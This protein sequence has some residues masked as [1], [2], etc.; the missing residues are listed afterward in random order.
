MQLYRDLTGEPIAHAKSC[1]LA[2]GGFDGLHVGH[3]ALIKQLTERAGTLNCQAVLLSFEPLPR[4]YF[5]QPGFFR[6][7]R[8][9]EKLIES[10]RLGLDI[11]LLTRFNQTLTELSPEQFVQLLTHKLAP[12]E[13]WVG[14]DFRFGH[15]R[16]GSVATLQEMSQRYGYRVVVVDDV[17][18]AG[19]RVSSSTI[20][21]L[22]LQGNLTAANRK[23]GRNFSYS[24][25]VVQGQQLARTLG[26]AT[27]NL[28][29]LDAPAPL[30]GVY[31][32][33]VSGEGFTQHKGVASLGVRPVVQGAACW[34]E[35][36]LFDFDAD[37][38]G[39]RLRVEFIEKLR[40]ELHF[41]GLDA[42][43]TQVNIDIAQAK[44]I[45]S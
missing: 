7:T 34:L 36:H 19:E 35:V 41:D 20:R 29:W 30:Y 10:M 18:H 43:I 26:F 24:N 5:R 1:V 8:T 27:A 42:L 25:R 37:L 44:A 23:L 31:A 40:P 3:Q 6:L 11:T 22:I 9:R 16:K 39:K 14:A 4:E 13:I 15:Q 2:L 33:R 21:A 45:L 28:L 32:V 38:Y 12:A 17:L